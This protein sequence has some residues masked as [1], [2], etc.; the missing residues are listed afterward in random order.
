M[1]DQWRD[2]LVYFAANCSTQSAEVTASALHVTQKYLV[3]RVDST[4]EYELGQ[5]LYDGFG[6]KMI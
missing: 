1:V 3:R 6:Q 2:A 5:D 4:A